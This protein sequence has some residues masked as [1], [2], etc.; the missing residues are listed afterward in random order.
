MTLRNMPGDDE[1]LVHRQIDDLSNR[2]DGL[3][4]F[5]TAIGW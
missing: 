3:I 4:V 2:E 5:S 1:R